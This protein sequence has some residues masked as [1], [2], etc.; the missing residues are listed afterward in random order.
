MAKK[1]LP[2]T[3]YKYYVYYDKK[4]GDILSVTNE[5]SN[6]YDYGIESTFAE[7]E[8]FLSGEWKFQDYLIGY[9]NP[10]DKSTIAIL[11]RDYVGYTFK[12]NLVEWV[13]ESDA[14]AECIVEWNKP[15]NAWH[16]YL[17]PEFK[18]TI[19]VTNTQLM[20]FVTLETD[21]DFLIRTIFIKISQLLKEDRV[22]VPF[23]SSIESKLDKLSISTK[24]IF[25]SYKLKAIYE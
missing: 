13:N 10:D 19:N 6:R 3:P 22:S 25:K 9:K 21:F 17:D 14:Y 23:E 16:F 15:N 24:V 12:N 8:R 1:N 7:V 2:N 5:K 20:F 4:S 11:S 18:K